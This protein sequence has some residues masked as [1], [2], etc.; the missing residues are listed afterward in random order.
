MLNNYSKNEDGIIYQVNKKPYD[1]TGEYNTYYKNMG[2][3]G[4]YTSHLR[5]GYIIGSIG[6][7]PNSILDVGYGTGAFLDSCKNCIPRRYGHDISGWNVPEGCRFV[8]NILQNYYDV[9]TFF[10]SLEHMENLEFVKDLQCEYVCI[11]LP[12]CHYF[13]DEWFESWKHRKPNEHLWHF[14]KDSLCNFMTR[15]GYEIINTCNLEDFTRPNH[16][17]YENILTGIFRKK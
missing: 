4:S 8:E 15:M 9:I 11:S 17:S 10:D 14:D 2:V 13:D 16:Q 7:V 1:Y 12:W 5:L 3:V 6:K